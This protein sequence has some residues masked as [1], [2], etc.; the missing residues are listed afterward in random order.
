MSDKGD[1]IR[2]TRGTYQGKTGWCNKDKESKK[3]RLY[4]IVD[5]GRGKMKRTWVKKSSVKPAIRSRPT[6]YSEAVLQQCPDLEEKLEKLCAELAMCK[7]E[8]DPIGIEKIISDKLNEACQMQAGKKSRA[9]YRTIN[10]QDAD[11]QGIFEGT[12]VSESAAEALRKR[13]AP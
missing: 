12:L 1:P 10:Y 2:F 7:I 11:A 4:V 3:T 8:K 6:S 5:L 13:K 9:L